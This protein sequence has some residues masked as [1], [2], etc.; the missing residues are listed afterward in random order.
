[1]FLDVDATVVLA[2]IAEFSITK[3]LLSLEIYNLVLKLRP[4]VG[5]EFSAE[6]KKNSESFSGLGIF[7]SGPSREATLL[8]SYP[9]YLC[10]AQ[11][12]QKRKI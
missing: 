10:S 4:I 9:C 5:F 8:P 3:T 12:D 11:A 1:M 6:I 7:R 2:V